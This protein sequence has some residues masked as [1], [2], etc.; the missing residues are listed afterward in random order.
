[1]TPGSQR[2]R[3]VSDGVVASY[4][5]DISTRHHGAR[6]N[7]VAHARRSLRRRDGVPVSQPPRRSIGRWTVMISSHGP[8]P[9][10]S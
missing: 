5:H 7:H 6:A 8:R 2:I 4:I 1:M 10:H 9:A 3:R